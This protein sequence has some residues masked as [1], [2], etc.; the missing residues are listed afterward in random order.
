MDIHGIFTA[1]FLLGFVFFAVSHLPIV[2]ILYIFI[3]KYLT[4]G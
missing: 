2:I 1:L 4:N 3:K